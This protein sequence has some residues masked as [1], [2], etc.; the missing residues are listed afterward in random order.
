MNTKFFSK[1]SRRCRGFSLIEVTLALGV[2]AFALLPIM[3]LVSMGMGTLRNS[4]DDTVRAVIVSEVIGEAQRTGWADL[5]DG[6][7]DKTFYYTDEGVR[8]SNTSG[9]VFLAQTQLTNS[10]GLL[11]GNQS[12]RLLQVTVRHF[13][14][15]NNVLVQSQLLVRSDPI[16]P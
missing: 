6:F 12:S 4:M 10:P 15:T 11:Q 7:N 1:H 14:D 3:G 13:G 2:I 16:K 9:S 5:D 8:L